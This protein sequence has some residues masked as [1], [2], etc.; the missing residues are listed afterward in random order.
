ME[1]ERFD[2]LA[3]ALSTVRSR[4]PVLALLSALSLTALVAR[5]VA[6]ACLAN[7]QRCGGGRGPCCSGRC[8]RKRDTTKKFCRAAANQG[9]CTIESNY[10]VN[11]V[12]ATCDVGNFGEC[13]C[14][15]TRRG[16]SFCAQNL[17]FDCSNCT[18]DAECAN[19]PQGQPGDRCVQAGTKCCADSDVD[20]LC[21][22]K[23]PNPAAA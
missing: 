6:A 4:R 8:V 2:T 5:D 15:V 18:S 12:S 7:G 21:A 14:L 19:R 10:C 22:H 17:G 3:R 11:T 9:I 20:W 1:A 16:F 23:C 13:L